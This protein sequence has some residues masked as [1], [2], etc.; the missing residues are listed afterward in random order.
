MLQNLTQRQMTTN[1]NQIRGM[2]NTL[3]S[4]RNPQAMLS[5]YASQNPQL[6]QAMD[7]VNQSGGDPQKCFY[8]LA[9]QMGVNPDDVLNALK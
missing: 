9:E 1:L 5:Q 7:L 3:K 4:I 6:K 2:M 8:N